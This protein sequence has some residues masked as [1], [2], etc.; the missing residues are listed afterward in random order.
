MAYLIPVVIAVLLAVILLRAYQFRAPASHTDSARPHEI[1]AQKAAGHLAAAVRCPTVS[2]GDASPVEQAAFKALHKALEDMY[3]LLHATA[4]KTLIGD[5]SLVYRWEGTDPELDPVL[6]LAHQDVVPA[7]PGSLD[8][9]THPPFSGAIEDGF[10]WGRGT[11]DCKNQLIG[12]L[13]AAETLLQDGFQPRRTL[14]FAF[15]HDEEI[16]GPNG[17]QKISSW[18]HEHG[19]RAA[20]VLDEG[21]TILKGGFPGVNSPV[22]VIGIV[23]KGHIDVRLTVTGKPGHAST[24]PKHTAIGVLARAI[25][26]IE[27]S[28]MPAHVGQVIPMFRGLG[29]NLPFSYRILFA[30]RWMFNGLL[31]KLLEANP[32]MNASIRTS[33]AATIIHGGVKENILPREVHA[34]LNIRLLPGDTIEEVLKHLQHVIKDDRIRLELSGSSRCEASSVSPAEGTVF[35]TL[36][37]SIQRIFGPIPVTPYIM[38]GGSDAR[39]YSPVSDRIYR[40]S[41]EVM[42]PEDLDRVHGIN[43]RTGVEAFARNVQ[44]FIDL[45]HSWTFQQDTLE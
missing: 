8:E 20:A 24:P 12:A 23:E 21:G 5:Y 37:T 29:A 30:N 18:L 33:C 39:H 43:E 27:A 1:D 45:I 10:I 40:F 15:G 41:P 28:P 2:H 44:F 9:W 32:Q 38:L 11:L 14:M 25:T 42:A 19:I 36:K 3:P 26:R 22:A 6:F 31:R 7:D 34:N 13:E 17:A 35:D 4:S 16:G